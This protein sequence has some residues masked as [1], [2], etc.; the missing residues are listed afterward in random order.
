MQGLC[1]KAF[2]EGLF[3]TLYCKQCQGF[4]SFCLVA[5]QYLLSAST[6]L[7]V[8]DAEYISPHLRLMVRGFKVK[9]NGW[10]LDVLLMENTA[11]MGVE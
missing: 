8:N 9:L 2:N 10:C 11:H 7:S 6:A 1:S 5:A 4:I 3:E